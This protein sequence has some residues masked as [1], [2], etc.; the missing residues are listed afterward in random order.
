MQSIHFTSFL[1]IYT[2]NKT[3]KVSPK[4]YSV[5]FW[6]FL[7]AKP[8]CVHY[9]FTVFLENM[10][11]V[12]GILIGCSSHWLHS[13]KTITVWRRKC[14]E[15][16]QGRSEGEIIARWIKKCLGWQ[17]WCFMYVLVYNVGIYWCSTYEFSWLTCIYC[18]YFQFTDMEY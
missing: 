5:L 15:C 1:N 6:Q 14:G 8:K 7:M 12:S 13:D 18:Y 2:V 10:C 3:L 4:Y 9:I 11:V 17:S 16:G